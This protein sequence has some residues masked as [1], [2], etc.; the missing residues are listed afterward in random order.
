MTE[1]PAD[2][3]VDRIRHLIKL[4]RV[5]QAQFARRLGIDPA[6]MSKHLSGKLPVTD[7]LVN[8][9]VADMGVS[10]EWL[11]NGTDVPFPRPVHAK[12]ITSMPCMAPHHGSVPVYNI[13]VTAGFGKLERMF[14]DDR[15]MGAVALPDL[16]DDCRIVRVSGD[17]MHPRIIDGGFVALRAISDLRN[18]YWGQIYVVVMEDYRMVK[19]VRR[20]NNPDKV[21]LHSVNPDYDDMEV[22]RRDIIALYLVEAIINYSLLC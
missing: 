13:D 9:I 12:E 22:D 2:T 20:H 7:G 4:E 17:S 1:S 21:I 5:S 14:T 3:I 15:I 18:I 16:S 6:N 11:R 19:T 8:R 10:K